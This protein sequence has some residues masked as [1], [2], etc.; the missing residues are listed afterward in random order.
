MTDFPSSEISQEIASP[1]LTDIINI[2]LNGRAFDVVRNVEY[3]DYSYFW[4]HFSTGH[5][6]ADTLSMIDG[7]SPDRS[8]F[9][10][11]G[12]WIG[13]TAL[14]AAFRQ[15]S[16]ITFEPDPIA[17]QALRHNLAL[18]PQIGRNI[19]VVPAAAGQ[20]NGDLELFSSN[21]GMSETSVF[22]RVQRQNEVQSA[23]TSTTVPMVDLA[24]FIRDLSPNE[25]KITIKIDV[26]G[27]EFSILPHIASLI[28]KYD[29]TLFATLHGQNIVEDTPDRTAASRLL[30]IAKCLEPFK[31][32]NWFKFERG[33][34]ELVDKFPYLVETLNKFG[35]NST[36]IVSRNML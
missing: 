31:H 17:L 20:R 23:L 3:A 16:V 26:E 7:I 33:C 24:Q 5:W 8:I 18:N 9:L 36:F 32:L 14:W 22:S 1:T 2:R 21:L 15:T 29:I 13:P 25:N 34:F 10:D 35:N 27:A 11:V 30:T 19:R 4:R 28:E 6:E 12:G